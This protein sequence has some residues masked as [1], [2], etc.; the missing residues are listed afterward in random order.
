MWIG[1]T[2]GTFLDY[3]R[4]YIQLK[5]QTLARILVHLDTHEGLEEKITL[6]WKNVT[7]V[8]I[9]DYEGIPFCYK[10]CHR[11]G[12]I[13][14]EFRLVKKAIEQL[15]P[16]AGAKSQP[17]PHQDFPPNSTPTASIHVV[18]R[19]AV[20]GSRRTPSPPMT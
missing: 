4:S 16:T 14:K 15:T 3:D 13:F 17:A 5:K 18:S 1:N 11:V 9:L 2:L 7:R 8:Q 12:H 20:E 6:Q 10:R 19:H